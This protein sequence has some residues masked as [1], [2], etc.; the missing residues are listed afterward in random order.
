[1][2]SRDYRQQGGRRPP[3]RRA[4]AAHTSVDTSGR[5][6]P[7]EPGSAQTGQGCEGARLSLHRA[8]RG[9]APAWYSSLPSAALLSAMLV[10]PPRRG[11]PVHPGAGLENVRNIHTTPK[12]SS[13]T[14]NHAP[15][16]QNGRWP[17][18][19]VTSTCPGPGMEET[20]WTWGQQRP[21][22]YSKARG[23]AASQAGPPAPAGSHH[24]GGRSQRG[25]ENCLERK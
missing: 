18:L 8:L 22:L 20:M 24:R 17:G 12:P 9:G 25:S 21:F 19:H 23:T 7:C 4:T 11:Q 2:K 10:L 1:M 15:N 6:G 13:F 3:R 14:R 5:C 16:Y